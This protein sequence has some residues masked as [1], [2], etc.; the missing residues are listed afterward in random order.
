MEQKYINDLVFKNH[1]RIKSLEKAF[2][3]FDPNKSNLKSIDIDEY[4]KQYSNLTIIHNNSCHDRYFILDRTVFYHCGAS[5]NHAGKGI[6]SI[7]KMSD[8][9]I[10]NSLL[11]RLLSIIEIK[12]IQDI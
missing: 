10:C 4:K 11:K 1:E 9:I 6:F 5:I 12:K 2:K 3:K 7:N 8:E